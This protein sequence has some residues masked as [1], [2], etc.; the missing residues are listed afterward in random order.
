V[1]RQDACK[2][3]VEMMIWKYLLRHIPHE[4]YS[5]YLYAL[6]SGTPTFH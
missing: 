6:I 1:I 3:K 2:T 5:T 4:N